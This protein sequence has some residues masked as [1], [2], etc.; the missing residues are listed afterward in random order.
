MARSFYLLA[1]VAALLVGLVGAFVPLLPTVPLL[2]L[3]AF[4][5]ARS[6]PR[7]EAWLV[8]HARLGPPIRAWRSRGAIARAGKIAATLAFTASIAGGFALLDWP[9]L[10]LPPVVAA[11]SLSWIW[12]RPD[13]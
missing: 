12:T 1:G 10:L 9:W 13:A 4:C 2:I 6:S 8:D 5:F 11:V 3:A 7:L